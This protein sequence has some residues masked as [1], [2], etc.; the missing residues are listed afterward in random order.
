MLLII[1]ILVIKVRLL[2]IFYYEY[3]GL[4]LHI[5][6]CIYNKCQKSAGIPI[7]NK[8]IDIIIKDLQK[9]DN[10]KRYTFIDFGCGEGK[11]LN[12]FN[13]KFKR[14]IGIEL[15]K[16]IIKIAKSK[17]KHNKNVII[18][19]INMLDYKFEDSDTVLYMYEPLWNIK[20]KSYCMNIYNKVFRNL[21]NV[22]SKSNKKLYVVYLTGLGSKDLDEEFFRKYKLHVKDKHKLAYYPYKFLYLLEFVN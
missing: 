20:S 15:D 2:E 22:F 5:K 14:L 19:N 10:M 3:E 4:W 8:Y 6:N 9:Y 16:Y 7:H 12:K 11:I 1:F 18:K 13:D 21:Y 17:N